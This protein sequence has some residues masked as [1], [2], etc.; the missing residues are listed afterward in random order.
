MINKYQREVEHYVAPRFKHIET[1]E[2]RSYDEWVYIHNRATTEA[3]IRT[4]ELEQM[5][6]NN[7]IE[8]WESSE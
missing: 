5:I 2:M 4:G 8:E 7:E 6:W 1:G 3:K